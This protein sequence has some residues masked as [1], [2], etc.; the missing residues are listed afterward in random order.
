[1]RAKVVFRPGA[2]G[3]I[4]DAPESFL[5][6]DSWPYARDV[7]LS[8]GVARER[9]GFAPAWTADTTYFG[10]PEPVGD[11]AEAIWRVKFKLANKTVW[12]ASRTW[13]SSPLTDSSHPNNPGLFG[14]YDDKSTWVGIGIPRCVYRDELI[15]CA[16]TGTYAIER[17]SGG[18]YRSDMPLG[19][20][21]YYDGESRITAGTGATEAAHT[22]G[23]YVRISL[24]KGQ[25]TTHARIVV[26]ATSNAN[27]IFEDGIHLGAYTTG[28]ARPF[29]GGGRLARICATA[30]GVFPCVSVIS[31]GTV[32]VTSL[33]GAFSATGYGTQWLTQSPTIP[34]LDG[35]HLLYKDNLTNTY[36]LRE[37]Q[38][39]IAETSFDMYGYT[40]TDTS[41]TTAKAEYEILVPPAWT[42]A[43]VHRGSLWGCG[44][45]QWPNRVYV[46][47]PGWNPAYPP[48]A[49]YPYD[50]GGELSA[51]S[52]D[53]WKLDFIDVPS[54]DDGDPVVAILSSPG[55]LLVLKRSSVYAIHGTYPN[56][57]VSPV[58]ETSGCVHRTAAITVDSQPYWADRNGIYTYR[59]GRVVDLTAGKISR[60][61]RGL[62]A[63]FD[64]GMIAM[65]AVA[66][67]LVVSLV[68]LDD[69]ATRY[70]RNEGDSA[71]P[72]DRVLV[73]SLEANEWVSQF[74]GVN[75][76]C[77]G[78]ARV[79]GE[80]DRLLFGRSG[81]VHYDLA[82]AFDGV[83]W[84]DGDDAPVDAKGYDEDGVGTTPSAEFYTP[85][86][87]AERAGVD[88]EARLLDASVV[89][90]YNDSGSTRNQVIKVS[91]D[92]GR[93]GDKDATPVT[94]ATIT[95][96]NAKQLQRTRFRVGRSG[97]THQVQ[98]SLSGA[99]ATSKDQEFHE[100]VCHFRDPRLRP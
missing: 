50:V 57:D 49:V 36:K 2:G 80:Q 20:T 81:A 26:T 32:A 17:Y 74:S 93:L 98:V 90:V 33:N 16:S 73:Y 7:V 78:S 39:N 89:T 71:N 38:S 67:H 13:G 34:E 11:Q 62:M 84:D 63:G 27:W 53:A 31:R 75:A 23:T 45:K 64:T 44:Q 12:V 88:G 18:G 40:V 22:P 54:R 99:P 59:G 35:A 65:G 24:G 4:T 15:L 5:K 10:D 97:R 6:S 56:F 87:L 48:G 72:T 55:P 96:T 1:V 29:Q 14:N 9:W 28:H 77:F 85:S 76:T 8:G 37:I 86:N 91:Q 69:N 95:R 70:G 19:A 58:S 43:T 52:P 25:V 41:K 60:Q 47:P 3:L 46:A 66:N 61:W 82:P 92:L 68:D 42:D 94:V 79:P 100:I 83:A 51:A 21:T 30:N